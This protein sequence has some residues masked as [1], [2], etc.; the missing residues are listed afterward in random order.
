MTTNLPRTRPASGL[1]LLG[2]E[3]SVLFRRKRTWAMLA[4]LAAG[5]L[6]RER[7]DSF[8]KLQLEIHFLREAEKRAARQDRK[9]SDRGARRVCSQRD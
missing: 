1:A 4:A 6:P 5:T 8:L 2:T 3:L 7:Y 9:K